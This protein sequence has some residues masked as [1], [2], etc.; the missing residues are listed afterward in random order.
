MEIGIAVIW[1]V[2]DTAKAVFNVDNY[3]EYL[4]LQC[5]SALRNVVRVYPMMFLPTWIPPATAWPTRAVCAAPLVVAAR[6][7][8]EIEERGRG[9]YRGGGGRIT[10]L[11]MH[12][13]LQ[14]SCCSAS[15][16]APSLTPAR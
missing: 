12:R 6:I 5:D 7:R 10:Y 16:P 9:R 3:K 4:S 11:A 1:R 8:D 15:R 13:K 2:T 14:R